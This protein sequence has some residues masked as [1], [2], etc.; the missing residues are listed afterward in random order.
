MRRDLPIRQEAGL[1]VAEGFVDVPL[2]PGAEFRFVVLIVEAFEGRQ[3]RYSGSAEVGV[4]A[5]E[6]TEVMVELFPAGEELTVTI[7]EPAD[8]TV[9][10]FAVTGSRVI[11]VRGTVSDPTVDRATLIVNG[12]SQEIPVT[13]GAFENPVVLRVGENAI[14]VTAGLIAL[15]GQVTEAAS[16]QTITVILL[17]RVM[18][19]L[20][21]TLTW[22]TT[23]DLD[24]HLINPR[25]GCGLL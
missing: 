20:R 9:V 7:T 1:R 16:S 6:V 21:V 18:V 8:G 23:A 5:E 14:R 19:G 17:S 24:L 13:G 12:A 10:D 11:T 25:G 22:N 15:D 4:H 3:L 2:P